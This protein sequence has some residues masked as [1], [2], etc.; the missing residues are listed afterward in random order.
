MQLSNRIGQL[1]AERVE[2][3]AA[4]AK[5]R[6]RSLSEIMQDLGIQPPACV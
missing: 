2:H 6:Q 1:D 5:L 4:L 3:L